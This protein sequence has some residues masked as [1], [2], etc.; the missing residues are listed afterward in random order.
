MPNFLVCGPPKCASTSLYF[1]LKQHPDIYMSPVKQTRFFSVYYDKGEEWYRQ[2]FFSGMNGEKMAGEAT[3][4]YSLLPFVIERIKKYNPDIKLIFCLRNPME[5]TFSG[6]SMRANNGTEHLS[7]REA[8]IENAKQ[9]ETI[10]FDNAKDAKEWSDDMQRSDR[11]DETGFRTYL[12]GSM[13]AQNL[14]QYYAHFPKENIKV[15]LLEDLN[16]NMHTTMKELFAFLDVDTEYQVEHTEQKNTYKKPKAKFLQPILGKSKK[17]SKLLAGVM[18][19]SVKKK[20]IDTMYEEGSKKKLTPEDRIF[21]YHYFK[22]EI[23]EL[24]K[25]LNMNLSHWKPAGK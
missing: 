23:E 21:A 2:S 11:Q 14:K 15:I 6:W 20:I 24:E 22:N 25:M 1:Y 9:R 8:L 10:K 13:Y 5:R 16:K 12:D 19:K 3:P 17:L 18:P 7:F 4:T